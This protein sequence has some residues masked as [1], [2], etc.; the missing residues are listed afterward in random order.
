MQIAD[1]CKVCIGMQ[2]VCSIAPPGT[3]RAYAISRS[4]QRFDVTNLAGFAFGRGRVLPFGSRA[5]VSA[6]VLL[7]NSVP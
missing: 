1:F 6:R 2:A 3:N 4:S 7:E 5:L